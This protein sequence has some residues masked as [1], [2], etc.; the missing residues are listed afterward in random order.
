MDFP[1]LIFMLWVFVLFA[2]FNFFPLINIAY[3]KKCIIQG[4]FSFEQNE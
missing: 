3:L 2:L 4:C 1:V